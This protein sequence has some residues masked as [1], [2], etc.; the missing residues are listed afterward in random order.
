[1][2]LERPSVA[3]LALPCDPLSLRSYLAIPASSWVDDFLDWLTPSSCC[4]LYTSGPNKDE[5]CPSTIS[6]CRASWGSWPTTAW[7]N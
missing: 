6:K 3:S 5:F 2:C 4:R 1:M 7:G